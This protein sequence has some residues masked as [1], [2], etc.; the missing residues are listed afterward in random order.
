ML[1]DN[2]HRQIG[3]RLDLF[4]F[5][6]EAPGMV[7]WHARGL[8]LFR[9]LELAARRQLERQ[10]YEE[11]RT[12]QLLKKAIWERSGHWHSFPEGMFVLQAEQAALKPVSCPG[13]VE[14]FRRRAA[15]FRDLPV[16]LAELGV[17]HRDEPSGTLQG[18][19][20]LRQFTQ[21]DGHVFC[22]PDQI[23]DEVVRFLRGL[24]D[25]YA[26]FGFHDVAVALS[27]RPEKRTGSDEIWDRAEALLA[28]S[29][30]RAG[31]EYTEQPGAGA[32]YGPKL[33]LSLR[34]CFGRAWQCGTIQLDFVLPESFD[35][36]YVDSGGARRRPAMLH[37]ALYGS[38]ERF[39]GVLLEH[40][41]GVLPAWLAPD[42]VVVTAISEAA[43]ELRWRSSGSAPAMFRAGT[44]G[45][46]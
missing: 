40:H 7:F 1:D 11:V 10:G 15:S 19:F 29:A 6:E 12:P 36:H 18:L 31:L 9:Q 22:A 41:G 43:A 42:Q 34:D 46:R 33:E 3:K 32:F 44:P 16:R 13:H 25:L 8:S 17:V 27:L 4:H 28:S 23:Q 24:F 45:P 38:V 26:A 21:D 5:Q 20:R 35:I 2:D 39:L 14:I 37:R 30:E